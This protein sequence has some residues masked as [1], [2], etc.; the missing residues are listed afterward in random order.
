MRQKSIDFN[1]EEELFIGATFVILPENYLSTGQFVTQMCDIGVNWVALRKNIY[2]EV[3]SNN[4]NIISFAEDEVRRLKENLK[5]NSKDF[6][7]EEQYGV[8]FNPKEDFDECWI[9]HVR[10]IVLANSSLHLCC[11]ARNGVMLQA[12]IG[13]LPDT[14]NPIKDLFINN[15][16]LVEKFRAY[17]PKNCQFCIDKDN[18]ISFS[19]VISLL[20]TSKDFEFT[21][22]N[23]VL[24][25][26]NY[27]N[28]IDH[29]II[30]VGLNKDKYQI[31]KNGTM[32]DLSG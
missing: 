31:F 23:V 17:V 25:D 24:S 13:G 32:V 7:I 27:I 5:S 16:G 1:R 21:K 3:Y 6:T 11:L 29:Q 9:S 20:K 19:N 2:R 26:K 28:P 10:S 8:S 4:P 22:A 30:E 14:E 12:N 15:K 18:N